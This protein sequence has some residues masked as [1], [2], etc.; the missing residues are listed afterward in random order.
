MRC[1]RRN[2]E[3][4]AGFEGDGLAAL[5]LVLQ[6]AL[7]NEGDFFTGMLV[8]DRHRAGIEFAPHL[9]DFLSGNAD[10][11]FDEIGAL[12]VRL[13]C[14][15]CLERHG[16]ERQGRDHDHTGVH[17]FLLSRIAGGVD[18]MPQAPAMFATC[19]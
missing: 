16:A 12:D 14:L 18:S 2:E 15:C 9:D 1:T 5:E 13:L 4:L 7:Q 11:A 10:I 8:I 6:R 3:R 17:L 19:D